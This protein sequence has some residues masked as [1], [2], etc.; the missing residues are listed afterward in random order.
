MR[1]KEEALDHFTY[2][3]PTIE[4]KPKFEAVTGEFLTLVDA[5]YDLMPDGPGKTL[6]LRKLAEA[7]MAVNSAIANDG[8]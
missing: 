4:T 2:K 1:T 6:A 8:Q 5:L 7:R 3:A